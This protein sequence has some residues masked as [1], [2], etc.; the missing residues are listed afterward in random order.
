M[1]ENSTQPASRK[2]LIIGG[3]IAAAAILLIIIYTIYTAT[4]DEEIPCPAGQDRDA[5]G[6]CVPQPCPTGQERDANGMCVPQPCPAEQE[7]DASGICVPQP[8]PTGQERDANGMCVPQPCPFGQERDVD[9]I[10]VAQP[11]PPGEFRNAAGVCSCAAGQIRDDRDQCLGLV[12]SDDF[13]RRMLLAQDGRTALGDWLQPGNLISRFVST[14]IAVSE[15]KINRAAVSHIKPAGDGFPIQRISSLEATLDPVGYRRYDRI[16]RT[17]EALDTQQTVAFIDM[18]E[19]LLDQ[20]YQNLGYPDGR[21]RPTLLNA[22]DEILGAP[23][24]T[25]EIRLV[26][27]SVMYRYAEN[28]LENLDDVKKQILRMG[29]QNTRII[30]SKLRELQQ[31]LQEN[32]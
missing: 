24:V 14:V 11:C 16:A 5:S 15:G 3:I 7:R 32:R 20:A 9:G 8:C 22:I 30:Q 25:G 12:G 17:V 19:P 4:Q 26:R 23:V 6:M 31:A 13:V 1:A 21:F 28:N 18:I 2:G 27:P 10:C 29:P